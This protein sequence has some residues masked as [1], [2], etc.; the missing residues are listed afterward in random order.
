MKKLLVTLLSVATLVLGASAF[1]H[2]TELRVG[3]VDMQQVFAQTNIVGDF[4]SRFQF[5]FGDRMKQFSVNQREIAEL[6][7]KLK[8]PNISAKEKEKVQV[9][10]KAE[11]TKI[12]E[13]RKSF[14]NEMRN[15]QFG[16]KTKIKNSIA[17]TA[18]KI[19]KQKNLDIVLRDDAVIFAGQKFD[20]TDDVVKVI[21][22]EFPKKV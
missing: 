8:D 17:N 4:Q 10:F 2:A 6:T 15:T 11:Q 12:M 14:S 7:K 5:Q 21:K 19:A 1:A 22:K 9:K 16:E 13:A 3:T 20:I 18:R